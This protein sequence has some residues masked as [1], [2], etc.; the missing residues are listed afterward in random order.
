MS[1]TKT[2]QSP[3]KPFTTKRILLM[4]LTVFMVT[5]IL[6]TI[7]A[8]IVARN[9]TNAF[10]SA[11]LLAIYRHASP[12][13]NAFFIAFTELGG[14]IVVTVT[15]LLLTA[16]FLLKSHYIKAYLI[17][18]GIG[19][20]AAMNLLLKSLFERARPDLWEWI[21]TE[22]HTSFPSGHATASMALAICGVFLVWHTKWRAVAI[23]GAVAYVLL[24]GFSR[25]YLG[26]HFPTDIIG[27]WLI[28]AGW[29]SLV[30]GSV[31]LLSRGKP[32]SK[33]AA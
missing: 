16:Y 7:L 22:T 21:V 24:I 30:I 6:F 8:I 25:L 3:L 9:D 1:T 11:A 29:M 2:Q 19:G 5:S 13:L 18:M 28:G 27:G 12:A 17:A 31:L 26:V 20:V 10:D 15:A 23:C 14:V 4:S 32:V 33:E